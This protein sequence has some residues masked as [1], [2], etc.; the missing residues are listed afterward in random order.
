MIEIEYIFYIDHSQP[1]NLYFNL[2]SGLAG[3]AIGFGSEALGPA[4]QHQQ[5]QEH[6][7]LLLLSSP[8][9]H[10]LPPE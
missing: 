9:G 2:H 1:T 4:P 8:H 7:H 3:A 5:C 10:S 6:D